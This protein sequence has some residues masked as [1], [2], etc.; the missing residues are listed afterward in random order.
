MTF[1][2]FRNYTLL[3]AFLEPSVLRLDSFF[4]RCDVCIQEPL[5]ATRRLK[6]GEDRAGK[7]SNSDNGTLGTH[8]MNK[9]QACSL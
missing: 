9:G 5:A 1:E 6:K 4:I 7:S 3:F 8:K 2:L